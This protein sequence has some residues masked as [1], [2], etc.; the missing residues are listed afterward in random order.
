MDAC[1]AGLT[2]RISVKNAFFLLAPDG[3]HFGLS[4]LV[5]VTAQAEAGNILG[6]NMPCYIQT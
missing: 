5:V 3:M 6:N 2:R 4:L 1:V